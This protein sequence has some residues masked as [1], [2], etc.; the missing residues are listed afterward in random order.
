MNEMVE[1]ALKATD[2]AKGVVLDGADEVRKRLISQNRPDIEQELK[3]YHR[4][5]DFI[6]TN[7]P[8]ADIQ[9]VAGTNS[10][11]AV[12]KQ[13]RKALDTQPK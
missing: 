11:A 12:A 2:L 7:F 6:R 13:I 5:F 9:T 8:D 1:E 4:E 3:N 10:P